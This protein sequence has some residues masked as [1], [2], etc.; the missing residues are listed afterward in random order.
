MTGLL[1]NVGGQRPEQGGILIAAV[2]GREPQQGHGV[3]HMV[4]GRSQKLQVVPMG[5]PAG[6]GVGDDRYRHESL[7]LPCGVV[8]KLR[9]EGGQ[10][11]LLAGGGNGLAPGTAVGGEQAER[12]QIP[13]APDEEAL[14]T[15]IIGRFGTQGCDETL[16]LSRS[17]GGEPAGAGRRRH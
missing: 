7:A 14:R 2:P 17:G 15:G 10:G 3:A 11:G 16:D 12:G 6:Q 13:L 8:F 4:V 5:Y 1:L 9:D